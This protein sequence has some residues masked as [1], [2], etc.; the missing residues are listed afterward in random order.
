FFRRGLFDAA[1]AHLF[2]DLARGFEQAE[3]LEGAEEVRERGGAL[4][5]AVI[6]LLERAHRRFELSV[7]RQQ[8]AERELL[9]FVLRRATDGGLERARAVGRAPRALEARGRAHGVV[10]RDERAGGLEVS[11]DAL[12]EVTRVPG[13]AP[14]REVDS[15]G[16]RLL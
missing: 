13:E 6:D 8:A 2:A 4:R 3:R 16:Q 10:A 7:A 5:G 1:A 12:V 15:R 9:S 11:A 14:R